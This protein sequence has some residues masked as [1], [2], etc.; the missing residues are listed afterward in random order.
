MTNAVYCLCS[1]EVGANAILTELRN[2]GFN[3]EI[4]VLLQEHANTRDISVKEDAIQ[5]AKI[6][7]IAGALLALAVPGL[8][9]ALAMG[10]LLAALG[11][12]SAGSVVGGLAGGSG[13]F[14]PLDLPEKVSQWLESR[15]TKG[16]ILVAVS[17]DDPSLRQKAERIFRSGGADEIYHQE[18]KAA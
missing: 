14:K 8:G 4:S 1:S 3:S 12:A 9:P 17:S 13:A 15:V 5:G 18:E 6:G 16:D 10:P 7:G 2:A 11:G